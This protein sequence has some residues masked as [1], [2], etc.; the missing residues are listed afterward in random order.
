MDGGHRTENLFYGDVLKILTSFQA[1]KMFHYSTWQT[2]IEEY[3]EKIN[4][5]Y[6]SNAKSITKKIQNLYYNLEDIEN[7]EDICPFFKKI[8]KKFLKSNNINDKVIIDINY[9]SNRI[10]EFGEDNNNI[11]SIDINYEEECI[12]RTNYKDHSH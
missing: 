1:L 2:S 10:P 7:N 11:L 8:F 9:S 6:K 12:N 5:N 3:F 4:N